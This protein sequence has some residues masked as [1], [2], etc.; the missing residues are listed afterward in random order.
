MRSAELQ[1]LMCIYQNRFDFWRLR[2]PQGRTK[3]PGLHWGLL[4]AV[5]WS[6]KN[7]N[8]MAQATNIISDWV[9]GYGPQWSATILTPSRVR[10]LI[11]R[12]RRG[13]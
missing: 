9:H 12:R 2:A 7:L 4:S 5:L 11:I 13:V 1:N 10:M 8:Y 6:R 3:V